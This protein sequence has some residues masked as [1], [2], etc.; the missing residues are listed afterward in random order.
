ML[1]YPLDPY[2]ILP[3]DSEIS[4][5]AHADDASGRVLGSNWADFGLYQAMAEV[6]VSHR[7]TM[8]GAE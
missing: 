5:A 2:E 4:S 8:V 3:T 1:N 6:T 7:L